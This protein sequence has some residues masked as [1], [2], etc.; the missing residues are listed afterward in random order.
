MPGGI[1]LAILPPGRET[2]MSVKLSKSHREWIERYREERWERTRERLEFVF[3]QPFAMLP[4]EMGRRRP[5]EAGAPVQSSDRGTTS[6]R[7]DR[8]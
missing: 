4:R 2:A 6:R 3:A 1:F 8:S 5:D 7:D